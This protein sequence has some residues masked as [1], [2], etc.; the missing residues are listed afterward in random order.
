MTEPD[1]VEVTFKK[2]DI[3]IDAETFEPMKPDFVMKVRLP[4]Q[5]TLEEAAE[6]EAMNESVDGPMQYLSM[7]QTCGNLALAYGLKYLWNMV[8][9]FQFL[10]FFQNWKINIHP[11][12]KIVLEQF[13]K[14]AFF[15]FI[16]TSWFTEYVQDTLGIER[17]VECDEESEEDCE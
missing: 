13:K 6:L 3:F 16:D 14:L 15:E 8:N 7:L 5:V 10:V 2:S 1:I 11:K 9:L 12:S 4:P 17:K